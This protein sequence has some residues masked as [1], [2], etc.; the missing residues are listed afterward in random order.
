MSAF[1]VTKTIVSPVGTTI[2]PGQEIVYLISVTNNIVPVTFSLVD[3][4]PIGTS[5]VSIKSDLSNSGG[6]TLSSLVQVGSLAQVIVISTDPLPT[7]LTSTYLLTIKVDQTAVVGSIIQ[8]TA[9][10]NVIVG[11]TSPPSFGTSPPLTVVAPQADLS[12][13][14]L[15]FAGTNKFVATMHNNGPSDAKNTVLV[16]KVNSAAAKFTRL[17]GPGFSIP[18]VIPTIF[19]LDGNDCKKESKSI[20]ESYTVRTTIATFPANSIATFLLSVIP[21]KKDCKKEQ[22]KLEV[23]AQVGSDTI[24]PEQTN[25][26]DQVSLVE[27]S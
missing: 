3:T 21:T 22:I 16:I 26:V 15:G 10:A 6:N 9:E 1:T 5:F 13:S 25:N 11:P 17:S 14:V 7:G 8:N 18:S 24:D 19:N 2:I 4:L 20:E 23:F 27:S 12:V